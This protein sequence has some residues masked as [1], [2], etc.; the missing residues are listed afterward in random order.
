[1][2]LD[3]ARVKEAEL[4]SLSMTEIGMMLKRQC[5]EEDK[6]EVGS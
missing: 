2:K 1:M 5:M 3:W 4:E 6:V